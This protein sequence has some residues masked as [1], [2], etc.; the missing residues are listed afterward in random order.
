MKFCIEE[1][2]SSSPFV[3]TIWRT[4]SAGPGLFISQAANYWEMVLTRH[5]G[6]PI[7]TVRGPETRATTIECQ[8]TEGE[9][10]G[11]IFKPGA[12][13]P[14]LPPGVVMDRKDLEL[15]GI[16]PQS[17]WLHNSA[18]QFPDYENVDTFVAQLARSGLLVHEPIV[19]AVLQ[20]Q[21]QDLSLRSLQYR[22]LH[23]TGLTCR[24][25]LQIE[26]ARKALA[27]LEQKHSI[28][29]VVYEAGYFDQPH[30]TRSLKRFFGQTPAQ[31]ASEN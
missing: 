3:E 2:P 14:H 18:W 11:I 7:F 1:R 21:Q 4:Q 23:A 15:P 25:F 9:F 30:L 13:M 31:I 8:W 20:G 19:D 17:F 26:R 6:Q 27:L 12:F 10:L 28:L 5:N 24:T 22:F 16:T 29:D